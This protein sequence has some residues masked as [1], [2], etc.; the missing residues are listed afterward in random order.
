M[1]T[2]MMKSC[3]LILMLVVIIESNARLDCSKEED[4]ILD[5]SGVFGGGSNTCSDLSPINATRSSS[6][7]VLCTAGSSPTSSLASCQN[8]KIYT[9][10]SIDS[11]TTIEC[12]GGNA[13]AGAEIYY[14]GDAT[15]SPSSHSINLIC[16]TDACKNM[17]IDVSNAGTTL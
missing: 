6:L 16:G 3:S 1:S 2:L 4:C 12:T 11:T 17:E 13:C 15:S 7:T 14:L 8:T 5:C 9:P 10:N